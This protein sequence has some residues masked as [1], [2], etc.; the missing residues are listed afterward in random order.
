MKIRLFSFFIVVCLFAPGFISPCPVYSKNQ[1]KMDH[2]YLYEKNP[3]TWRIVPWGGWGKMQYHSSGPTFDFVFNGHGLNPHTRYTLIYYPDPWP[4]DGLVEIGRG[5]TNRGGN[6][7]IAGSVNLSGDLPQPFDHNYPTGAKIWLVKSNDVDLIGKRMVHWHPR[8][9]LFEGKLIKYQDTDDDSGTFCLFLSEGPCSG[10]EV[11]ITQWG[12]AVTFTVAGLPDFVGTGSIS[13]NIMTLTGSIP[14]QGELNMIL[15]FSDD[16]QTFSGTY[17]LGTEE[18][19]VTGSRNICTDPFPE[20]DPVSILPVPLADLD[21]VTGGQPFNSSYGGV[22]H[23][24]LDFKFDF[25]PSALPPTIVSPCDGVVQGIRKHTIPGGGGSGIYTI[26]DVEIRNNRDW[27]TLVVFEPY[28]NDPLIAD[29]QE[30]EILVGRCQVVR[31]GDPLGRLVV[32]DTEYPH[33]HWQISQSPSGS[34][35]CPR[36]FLS[37]ADQT[38]LDALY[39]RLPS[40]DPLEANLLPVCR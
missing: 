3:W 9:Y 22:V 2:L 12:E 17:S 23:T 4:G 32:P 20:G 16:R 31:R 35:F 40:P 33:L 11:V 26:F 27:N 36:N 39:G 28:S 19:T 5:M 29:Q 1:N 24:G 15:T 13:G 7:N 6:I 21:L 34:P 30:R 8:D 25:N 37:G 14:G 10:I 18:G 38:E